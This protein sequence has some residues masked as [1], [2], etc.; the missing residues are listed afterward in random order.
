MEPTLKKINFTG[1]YE[2]NVY[3]KARDEL[4]N[5]KYAEL[6]HSSRMTNV[7]SHVVF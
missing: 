5:G 1:P 7:H 6:W 2:R 4:E 3:L